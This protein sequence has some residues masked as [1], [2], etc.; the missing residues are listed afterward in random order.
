MGTTKLHLGANTD[1][2]HA[3]TELT[4]VYLFFLDVLWNFGEFNIYGFPFVFQT[5]AGKWKIWRKGEQCQP[6]IWDFSFSYPEG[7]KSILPFSSPRTVSALGYFPCFVLIDKRTFQHFW[8]KESAGEYSQL[9]AVCLQLATVCTLIALEHQ[10]LFH[11]Y[12]LTYL[13]IFS[14]RGKQQKDFAILLLIVFNTR[15][16]KDQPGLSPC[17]V[18]CCKAQSCMQR[19]C[20]KSSSSWVCRV[21]VAAVV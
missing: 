1:P 12:A 15:M 11:F 16:P 4:F 8:A 2:S 20:T 9:M 21:P 3:R 13:F 7:Q 10:S 5:L 17:C 18:Q 6:W 19:C 14:P